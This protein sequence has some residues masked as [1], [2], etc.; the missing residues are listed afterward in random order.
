MIVV[1]QCFSNGG[2]LVATDCDVTPMLSIL[3][4]EYIHVLDLYGKKKNKGKKKKK[5]KKTTV[6]GLGNVPSINVYF[7]EILSPFF[8]KIGFNIFQYI[9]LINDLKETYFIPNSADDKLV[10][11]FILL[12]EK[13]MLH[14]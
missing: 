6:K 13:K 8:R 2:Y 3:M 5:K 12:K 11:L 9:H 10:I 7:F 14:I 4:V 1:K